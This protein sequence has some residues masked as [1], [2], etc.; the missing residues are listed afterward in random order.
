[1]T[2]VSHG[3]LNS[4]IPYYTLNFLVEL[5]RRL[6]DVFAD[7]WET[8]FLFQ[9]VSVAIQSFKSLLLHDTFV[10]DDLNQ[11]SSSFDFILGLGTYTP[12]GLNS[13]IK[14]K[15]R[16]DDDDDNNNNNNNTR[17]CILSDF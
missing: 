16:N 6:C 4:S 2:C 3:T 12:L 1:M 5:G 17:F 10:D 7:V 14:Q 13:K 8:S 11:N 15:Q 9:R